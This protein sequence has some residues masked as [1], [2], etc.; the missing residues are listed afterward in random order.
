MKKGL[1]LP[2]DKCQYKIKARQRFLLKKNDFEAEIF[3]GYAKVTYKNPKVASESH[4]R[5]VVKLPKTKLEGNSVYDYF[6][7][8]NA[9]QIMKMY[10]RDLDI[11]K[12]KARRGFSVKYEIIDMKNE[13]E[14]KK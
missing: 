13:K 4:A 11:A 1:E 5:M 12:M 10:K 8:L 14:V 9:K 2:E 3:D 7:N 6:A